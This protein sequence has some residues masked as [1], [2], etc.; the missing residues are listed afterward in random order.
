MEGQTDTGNSAVVIKNMS[1]VNNK[2]LHVYSD[3]VFCSI[4]R[5]SMALNIILCSHVCICID[6]LYG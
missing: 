6:G 2:Y 1:K 4:Y 3:S 5:S